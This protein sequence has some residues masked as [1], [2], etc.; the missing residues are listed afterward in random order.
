MEYEIRG[1]SDAES[2]VFLTYIC[3]EVRL[4]LSKALVFPHNTVHCLEIC[5]AGYTS[6]AEFQSEQW[7]RSACHSLF[8]GEANGARSRFG[9]RLHS[10]RNLRVHRIIFE[11]AVK[12]EAV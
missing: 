12:Q 10:L 9:N 6:C 5:V 8:L 7:Y 1:V 2:F 3:N 11:I 4:K